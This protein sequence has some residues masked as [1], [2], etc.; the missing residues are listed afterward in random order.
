MLDELQ[1]FEDLEQG[2]PEW[3]A[4]RCG[5]VTASVFHTVLAKGRG[6]AP[7]ET[8]KKLLYQLAAET[9]TG[10]YVPTWDGNKHTERGHVMEPQV[11]D[12]YM[13]TSALDCRQVGFMRRGRIG[14]SPDTLVGDEGL[15]EIKTKLPHLQIEAVLA[16]K[17]PSDHVAQVQG[18]LLVSGRQWCDFRSYWPGLPELRVRVY[19]DLPYLSTLN[20]ELQLFIRELDALVAQIKAMA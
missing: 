6:G 1:I 15:L 9:I 20:Q 14:C 8:R 11:R 3:H 2:T 5:V 17:L 13:A 7:S 16:G 12:L 18:Q 4:A 19:R 10:E